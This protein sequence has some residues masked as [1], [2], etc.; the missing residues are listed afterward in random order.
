MNAHRWQG[1]ARLLAIISLQA[2]PKAQQGNSP[3]TLMIAALWF[4]GN[5]LPIRCSLFLQAEGDN[6]KNADRPAALAMPALDH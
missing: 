1:L 5:G 2:G 4:P 6:P 3:K